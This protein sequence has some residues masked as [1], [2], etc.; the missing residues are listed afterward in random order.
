MG[1]WRKNMGEFVG[2][3]EGVRYVMEDGESGGRM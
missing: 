2:I 1:K 3:V